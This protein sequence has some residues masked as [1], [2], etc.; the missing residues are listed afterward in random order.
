[1]N[2]VEAILSKVVEGARINREEGL[3]LLER[4]ELSD[5]GRTADWVRF[6]HH[7]DPIVTYIVDRNINYTNVCVTYCAFCAFYRTPASDQGYTLTRGQL[8]QKI[9]ETLD[10]GGIQILL[11]GGHHPDYPIGWYE[12]LLR[13]IKENYPI[14]VHG[15]SPPEIHHISRVSALSIPEVL[16]RLK[17]AGLDTIPG[18]GAEILV[19]RVRKEISPLKTTSAEW[20]EVMRQAH[21]L[22]IRSTATMM[23]GHVETLDERMDHL[24]EIRDLQ[25]EAPVEGG[26]T[27]FICWNLQSRNTKLSHLPVTGGVDYL[28]TLAVARIFLDNVPNIQSSWVT[29][30]E[31]IGQMALRFGANDMGST[32]IE[33]NVVSQAGADFRLTEDRIRGIIQDL[34]YAPRRRTCYYEILEEQFDTVGVQGNGFF[35][36]ET[37]NSQNKARNLS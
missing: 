14:H 33:E 22:G 8:G 30:G 1:M 3:I 2:S 25:E 18:G 35:S 19:D 15:F 6:R 27:A 26:F 31:K 10:Q 5:L 28:R 21:R 11:Q 32:M 13:F 9:R 17:A 24:Q 23:Y 4:A 34:G 12:D 36:T 20:L 16:R 29:Q 37:R 7:P